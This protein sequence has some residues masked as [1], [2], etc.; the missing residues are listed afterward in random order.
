[1][2]RCIHL[3]RVCEHL[4]PEMVPLGRELEFM[5]IARKWGTSVGLV[6][7]KRAVTRLGINPGDEIRVLIRKTRNLASMV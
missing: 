1:M 6:V 7:Q 5:T 4:N 2:T 3:G